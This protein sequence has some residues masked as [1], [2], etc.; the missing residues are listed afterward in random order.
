M[1]S[2]LPPERGEDLRPPASDIELDKLSAAQLL[3][4]I[5]SKAGAL[6]RKEVELAQVELR[7][8]LRRQKAMVIGLGISAVAALTAVHLL[9]V[10]GVLAL[11]ETLALPGWAAA[12]CV[13]A[14]AL[15]LSGIVGLIGWKK[16]V[17]TPLERTRRSIEEGVEWTKERLA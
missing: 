9:F 1:G 16:R 14:G 11:A 12:L 6:V 8:D 7:S 13:A 10:A 2:A 15:V 4:E 3:K 17:R 5:G